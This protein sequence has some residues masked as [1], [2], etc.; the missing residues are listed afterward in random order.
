MKDLKGNFSDLVLYGAVVVGGQL[1]VDNHNTYAMAHTYTGPM[2]EEKTLV[3]WLYLEDLDVKDGSALTIDDLLKGEKIIGVQQGTTEAKW[4]KAQ[5]ADKGWNLELR[6]YS[7]SPLAIEDVLNGR[8]AAAAMD[9]APA[10]DAASKKDIQIVGTF[11]MDDEE[12]GYA[13][14]KDDKELLMKVNKALAKLKT[15]PA[16]NEMIEKFNLDK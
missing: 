3:S 13:V 4:L 14:R 12:F 8:I 15:T 10:K 7:S 2:I 9:D 11:G 6:Y 16:W 1:D 5:A